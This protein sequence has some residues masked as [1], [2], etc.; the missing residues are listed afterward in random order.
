ML[1]DPPKRVFTPELIEARVSTAAIAVE[2]VPNGIHLVII[3]MIILG[4]VER[5]GGNDGGDDG[6]F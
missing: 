4:R 3:L 2:F 6:L 1:R 5:P